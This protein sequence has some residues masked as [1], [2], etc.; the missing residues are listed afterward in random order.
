MADVEAL[1]RE[2]ENEAYKLVTKGMKEGKGTG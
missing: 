1:K 2:S